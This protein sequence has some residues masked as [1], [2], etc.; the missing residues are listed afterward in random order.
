MPTFLAVSLVVAMAAFA[1]GCGDDSSANSL[2]K[3]EFV[4]QGDAVCKK[5]NKAEEDELID[6]L[7]KA[8][9]ANGGKPLT[10]AQ[11]SE[12]V[13]TVVAPL[14]QLQVDTLNDLGS[15]EGSEEQAD[16]FIAELEDVLEEAEENPVGTAASGEPFAESEKMAKELGFKFCGDNKGS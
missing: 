1:A 16:A 2:S 9:R 6:Y 7:E 5:A 15:P 12:L 10:Q 13:T 11:E 14:I 4:K 8:S 3:A